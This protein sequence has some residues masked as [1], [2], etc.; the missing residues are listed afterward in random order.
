M[1]NQ[2]SLDNLRPFDKMD[3]EKH[4][5]LSSKGGKACAKAKRERKAQ[6]EMLTALLKYGDMFRTFS[7]LCEMDPDKLIE[8]IDKSNHGKI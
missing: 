5:E 3:S 8:M 1:V 6:Q 7:R 2:K 4:R